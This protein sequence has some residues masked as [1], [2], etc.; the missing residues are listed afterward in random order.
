MKWTH[1]L[2]WIG[3]IAVHA[4][5][6]ADSQ[7]SDTPVAT[8]GQNAEPAEPVSAVQLMPR[9]QVERYRRLLPPIEDEALQQVIDDSATMWY[10]HE[11]MPPAYQDSIP[12]FVGIL[13][14]SRSGGVAPAEFFAAGKFRFPF[15]ATGGA[16]RVTGL[17]K[18][19]FLW[20]PPHGKGRLPIVWWK[21]GYAYHWMFPIGTVLGEVLL[22]QADSGDQV[23]FEVRMRRRHDDH[24]HADAFRPFPSASDLEEAIRRARPNWS[25]SESSKA[26]VN[27]LRD[28]STIQP[29][30]LADQYGAFKARGALDY[31]PPI[32]PA[33]A[34]QLLQTAT[35]KSSEG[36]AWKS[37]Q[38]LE[39][40]APTASEFSIVPARYDAGLIAVDGTSC[41]RCHQHAGRRIGYFVPFQRLYGQVWGSDEVFSWH[42]FEPSK[43]LSSPNGISANP[44]RNEF[45]AHGVIERY[46]SDKHSADRYQKLPN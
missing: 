27:H 28:P 7:D 44:L 11:S 12:P 40:Y 22:Q 19:N 18:V 32:E 4:A 36:R 2:V 15:G 43:L 6:A 25:E 39:C 41:R 35:F 14:T 29:R 33:L 45:E 21:E 34:Q 13:Q 5:F 20:L 9:S 16:H 17:T 23:V 30:V 46:H 10:D 1:S 24:W 37:H 8:S 38:G 3:V 31:L 42:P 26:L